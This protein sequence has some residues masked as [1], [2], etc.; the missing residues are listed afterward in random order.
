MRKLAPIFSL[1][2][3]E[4]KRLS[5][6]LPPREPRLRGPKIIPV[7]E[8]NIATKEL[9]YVTSVVSS[10]WISSEGDDVEKFEKKFAHTVSKTRYAVAVNS[11]TSALH[12]ALAALGIGPGDEVVLPVF[13]MIAT[14]NAVTYCGA[15]PV[16]VDA[17]PVSWNMDTSLIETKITKKTKA[18]LAVHVYGLPADMD[19]IARL[20]K[21]Y[22][23]WVVEDAAEAQGAS[24]HGYAVGGIGDVAAFSL[25]ANKTVTTGE[26]GVAVTNNTHIAK[27]LKLLRNHAF[28]EERHFWHTMV[29]FGYRMTNM[30][31]AIGLAQV[32]R[33]YSFFRL[34]RSHAYLYKKLLRDIPGLTFPDEPRD[35]VNGYWMF[36]VLVDASRFGMDK[37]TLR[38]YLAAHGI[39]TRSFFIPIH[40]QPV[41]RRFFRNESFPVAERLCRDGLYLPSSTKLTSRDVA[42]IA[43]TIHDAFRRKAG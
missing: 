25:Y 17:D 9:Q 31:A 32:E 22:R 6:I 4:S 1:T 29:G 37:N 20:A 19:I 5:S 33:F 3:A 43:R 30:Q 14:V 15:T 8:P 42:F 13:T 26:G 12:I 28:T 38:A 11:G 40:L 36:G 21:K 10:S 7:C 35:V 24:F 27:R 2:P 18:I 41:Y 39:E 34:K 16:I 23:L